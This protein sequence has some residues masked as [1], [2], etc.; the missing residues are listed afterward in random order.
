MVREITFAIPRGFCSGALVTKEHILT[1]GHCVMARDCS[2][3][4]F[5]FRYRLSRSNFQTTRFP[6][7][8]VYSCEKVEYIKTRDFDIALLK[9]DRPIEQ[10]LAFPLKTQNPKSPLLEGD[11]V[12]MIGHPDGLPQ[13]IADGALVR[14]TNPFEALTNLD[15]Y[16]GNSGSPVFNQRN[17][18]IEGVLVSGET[19]YVRRPDESCN[20]SKVCRGEECIGEAVSFIPQEL[21]A[22][23]SSL[24]S[25]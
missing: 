15:A 13:K 23:I 9:M 10:G 5:V 18:L 22:L 6:L 1:A 20:I 21:S 25:L 7:D 24:Q 4:S 11:K 8:H 16:R 3:I 12:Y 14:S 19:D 2:N 17:N